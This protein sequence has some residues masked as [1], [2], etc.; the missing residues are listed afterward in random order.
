MGRAGEQTGLK[1]PLSTR[2]GELYKHAVKEKITSGCWLAP[3]SAEISAIAIG[4]LLAPHD[5]RSSPPWHQ[6]QRRPAAQHGGRNSLAT[7]NIQK[8]RSCAGFGHLSH[9]PFV[10]HR[11]RRGFRRAK[12]GVPLLPQVFASNH[13][14]TACSGAAGFCKRSTTRAMKLRCGEACGSLLGA[15]QGLQGRSSGRPGSPVFPAS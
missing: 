11:V 4:P 1:K 6:R 10:A 13:V 14:Q 2:F 12:Q 7:E 8:R 15:T 9:L 5:M 3:V